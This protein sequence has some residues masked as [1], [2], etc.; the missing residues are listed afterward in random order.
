[1]KNIAFILVTILFI[2]LIIGYVYNNQPQKDSPIYGSTYVN[3]QMPKGWELHLMPGE[4]TVIWMGKDPRIR[5]IE[6]KN[7]TKFDSIYNEALNTDIGSYTVIKKNKTVDNIEV[8][9]IKTMNNHDGNIQD[10]YFF[11]K[12]NK[13]YYLISWAF[14]GWDS[15]SQTIS[16]REVDNATNTIIKTIQ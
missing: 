12:N 11:K 3:F 5:I 8:N 6:L 1:M 4:G 14:T 7:K 13:Y 2:L 15:A 9:I 10:F 16:R